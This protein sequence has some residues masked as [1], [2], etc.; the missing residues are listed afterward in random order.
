[1][2][3]VRFLDTALGMCLGAIF[4]FPFVGVFNKEVEPYTDV[5]YLVTNNEL[6]YT[7]EASFK[8]TACVFEDMDVL[9]TSLGYTRPLVWYDTE[10]GKGNREVGPQSFTLQ[11]FSEQPLSSVKVV[12]RHTC[13]GEVVENVFLEEKL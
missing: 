13:S 1:M 8:K 10:G 5:S 12:T 9:G 3:K 6:G 11:V 4:F 7:V 2:F